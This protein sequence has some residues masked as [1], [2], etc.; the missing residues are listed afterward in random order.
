MTPASK[1]QFEEA[2]RSFQFDGTLRSAE[3]YGNGHI[4]DTYLLVFEIGTMGIV[5]II[6]QRMNRE[7]F[8]KAC[9][10]NGKHHGRNLTSSPEDHRAGRRSGAGD[11]ERDSLPGSEAV[12]QGFRRRVLES[13][14]LYHRRNQFRPSGT[15][16]KTFTRVRWRSETFSGCCPIIRRPLSTRQFRDFTIPRPDSVRSGKQ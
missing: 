2:I 14:P 16:R 13:L 8:Y 4:N 11:T 6:L 15:A 5:K 3:P 12:L 10:V 9:G 7:V 1:E